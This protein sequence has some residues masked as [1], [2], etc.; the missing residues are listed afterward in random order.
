[1]KVYVGCCG[2]AKG[3][4]KYF[5][6]YDTVEIQK[7]FYKLQK[8]ATLEKWRNLA[9][10]SFIFNIKVFQGITHDVKSPTW[11]RSSIE[12]YKNL[13][14]KVGYLRP[15]KEVFEYWEKMLEYAR[16]LKAR[17]LVIQLPASFR[18]I[19]ENWEN[20]EKFF[21]KIDRED[22]LI[23][24]ELRRWSVKSIEKFCKKFRV[25]DV[26]DLFLRNP[27][28]T[29]NG[30]AYFRLHGRYEGSRI[31]YKYRYSLQELRQLL[32]RVLKLEDQG[33]EET[34]ILFNNVYMGE[35]ALEFKSLLK[36][37]NL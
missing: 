8:T 6:E 10:E 27:S 11:K 5:S 9:P 18:D 36:E 3:M 33:V 7:I 16:V 13:S 19:P 12:N 35:N 24:V 29:V 34:Y 31:N 22:F 28:N 26:C 17:V 2:F 4:K 14:G 21:N 1:M 32:E 30:I 37:Y 20:A 15:T 25:I 23:G